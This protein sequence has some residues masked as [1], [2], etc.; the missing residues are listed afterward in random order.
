[1]KTTPPENPATGLA[2]AI[3]SLPGI[4]PKRAAT[5]AGMGV[6][7]LRDLL[8]YFPRDY[9]DRRRIRPIALVKPG[10]YV[11]IEAEVLESKAR[12]LRK[13]MALTEVSLRDASGEMKAIWFGPAYLA[14]QFRPGMRGFFHGFAEDQQG[15]VLKNPEHEMLS[16]DEE[17]RIHTGRIVPLYR[18][19]EGVSQR[20]LRKWIH[21]ALEQ[22]DGT[23]E[24]TLPETLRRREGF[25]AIEDAVRAVHYPR[26][27]ADAEAAKRRFVYEELLGMQA[28]IVQKR[29]ARQDQLDGNVHVVNG[30]FLGELGGS[31]PFALTGAQKRA[32][33]DIL[34][35]MAAPRPM[36][37]LVQGDVGCGKTL[38]AMMA[39]AAAADGGFQTAVLAPTEILAE[40]HARTF[41]ERLEPLGLTV[42][43]LTR[44][45]VS[46]AE[47][48]KRVASSEAVVVVGTHAIIQE[49]VK[50]HRLGL[51]IIDEQHRFGVMQRATLTG[52]G[53]KPDIL[54]M[55]A[56]PIPRTLAITLY[57]GM[58]ITTIDELPPGRT[59][60]KTS[61]VTQAKVPGLYQYIR[62]QAGKGFQT[63]F[64][65]PLVDESELSDL[66]AVTRHFEEL[67]SGPF[68]GLR[69]ALLHGRMSGAEKDEI[70]RLLKRR[71]IDVL[72]STTVIEVGI[73]VPTATTMVIEDSGQF[74]LTQLHQ[75]RG[76]VGR[77]AEQSYC[78]LLGKPKTPDA[79]QRIEVMC[80]T[81]DGFVIAEEDLNL[82]GPG[83]LVGVR[84]AGLQD[85][86][87]ADL[88]RDAR[89][90]D[91]ARRD[92]ESILEDDPHLK[93]REHRPLAR[94][95]ERFQ[96]LNA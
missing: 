35:D 42:E 10:E 78:F 82:R 62:E 63:Y 38:V 25:P 71:E 32:V 86:Q 8:F 50:F 54:H 36:L 61:Y 52:K 5:L 11:T 93:K 41:R 60:V 85:L 58:D 79:K 44:S 21:L 59:P 80:A 87:F 12:H 81:T 64:V 7:T 43:L 72:F 91:Q 90:I 23:L 27:L 55:T 51:V 65:C 74:G 83:E 76:R 89:L 69:T 22:L 53:H 37:R 34:E 96:R 94:A 18:L 70:M 40:Q 88:L 3:D 47:A 31:L 84:Q 46:P 17:D 95:S 1:M 77:G 33:A 56:T 16:G 29:R 2:R 30:P 14:R 19:T 15:P 68:K 57:G 6:S 92:A 28:G 4:G 75:L 9:R 49:K 45:T 73:D 13:R 26:S 39:A 67:S 20:L 66:T 48:R 24:E